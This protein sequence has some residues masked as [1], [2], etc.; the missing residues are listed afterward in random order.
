MSSNDFYAV[1]LNLNV[2]G[3]LRTATVR[4]ADLL[5]DVL[6]ESFGLTG[7]KPGCRNGDCGTCTVLLDGSPMK[8]CLMLAVETAGK[9]GYDC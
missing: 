7:A 1:M 2:N 3:E 9:K 5:L 6:R 4:P 8:S